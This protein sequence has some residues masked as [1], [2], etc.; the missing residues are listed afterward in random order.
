MK[1]RL[2]SCVSEELWFEAFE[3]SQTRFQRFQ[4]ILNCD[5]WHCY[6]DGVE[7]APC[8]TEL[9]HK[10][11]GTEHNEYTCYFRHWFRKVDGKPTP[12]P[13]SHL[14]LMPLVRSCVWQTLLAEFVTDKLAGRD[15]VRL[16]V[17]DELEHY[18]NL[19]STELRHKIGSLAQDFFGCI[20]NHLSATDKPLNRAGLA[21]AE[22]LVLNLPGLD[23]RSKR[24][25]WSNRKLRKTLA[26][27][28]IDKGI[29]ELSTRKEQE[30]FIWKYL[31]VDNDLKQS[32]P[33]AILKLLL[34]YF[35]EDGVCIIKSW[36]KSE[37]SE[38]RREAREK[39]SFSKTMILVDKISEKISSGEK[40]TESE[41]KFVYR[42]RDLFNVAESKNGTNQKSIC[43]RIHNTKRILICPKPEISNFKK[44][45]LSSSSIVMREHFD[46]SRSISKRRN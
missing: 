12:H 42:H 21:G 15:A 2:T 4:K 39:G 14:A 30:A 8:T 35:D 1:S 44:P 23:Y 18:S 17:E 7:T 38:I 3:K 36:S 13:F 41:R 22:K 20:K 10:L 6:G 33:K 40:L 5:S 45:T 29:G 16:R 27:Q 31:S 37:L 46:L 43:K 32:A 34:N 26:Q 19:K 11:V 25:G 28:I 24:K 9:W